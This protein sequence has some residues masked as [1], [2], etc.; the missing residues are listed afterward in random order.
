MRGGG[1]CASIVTP[2]RG[3][4][5]FR[6]SH[7]ARSGRKG[8]RGHGLKY[9]GVG[10]R[11]TSHTLSS[12]PFMDST[13]LIGERTAKEK[14]PPFTRNLWALWAA[15][16]ENPGHSRQEREKLPQVGLLESEC[17]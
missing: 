11:G 7:F 10:K 15:M 1:T 17:G 4:F 2:E 8:T 14:K 3:F 12:L 6:K 13:S 9:F 5:G 16:G